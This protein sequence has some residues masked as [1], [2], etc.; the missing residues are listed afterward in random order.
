MEKH[1]KDEIKRILNS[2]LIIHWWNFRTKT[3]DFNGTV[4]DYLKREEISYRIEKYKDDS[5]DI[6]RLKFY[7]RFTIGSLSK[8]YFVANNLFFKA[9]KRENP[10]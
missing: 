5:L 9:M 1:N 2:N 4:K 7:V 8:V 6:E 10:S 3:L